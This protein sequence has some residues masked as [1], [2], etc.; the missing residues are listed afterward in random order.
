MLEFICLSPLCVLSL[1][2]IQ[3]LTCS[4][5]SCENFI[6]FYY[7][8]L[9][10]EDKVFCVCLSP[11]SLTNHNFLFLCSRELTL[12][13]ISKSESQ[14][15]G[16]MAS[17]AVV[18]IVSRI[19]EKVSAVCEARGWSS[20]KKKVKNSRHSRLLSDSCSE[21]LIKLEMERDRELVSCHMRIGTFPQVE[22]ELLL[23]F[24]RTQS[25]MMLSSSLY[26][27]LRRCKC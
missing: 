13:L 22:T 18:G 12:F 6:S 15:N 25:F 23:M 10:E 20:E 3:F 26:L 2:R 21:L 9:S 11:A 7:Y 8:D 1:S 5:H 17:D 27:S 24:V 16:Q 19:E 14:S 4:W